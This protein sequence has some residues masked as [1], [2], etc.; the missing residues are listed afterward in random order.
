MTRNHCT[1]F[2]TIP[3]LFLGCSKV[4]DDC[5]VNDYPN[6]PII[7]W[8]TEV[9]GSE[10]ESH[11]HFILTC[12][13]EGYLQVGETGVFPST[14]KILV[15]KTDNLGELVWKKEFGTS[16]NN[17]GNSAIETPTGYIICGAIDGN[18]ALI[19]LDKSTGNQKFVRTIENGGSNAFENII[20][21]PN[22][23]IAVGYNHAEDYTNTFFTEGRGYITFL[24]TS[25]IKTLGIGLENYLAQ[26]YRI[27]DY[28]NDYYISGLT[29]NANDY[30]LIKL[31]SLGNILWHRTYGGVASDHC[32]GMAVG[33]DG[34]IFLTGH[35]LSNTENWDTYTI[36]IDPFGNV[37]WERVAGNPRGFNPKFIH[38]EAWDIKCLPDGSCIVV[39]GTGDEYRRYTRRCGNDGDNSNT[40]HIYLIKYDPDGNLEWQKTYGGGQNIDWAGEA[41]DLTPDGG[42]II[43][44]DNGE[45]GFVKI[46]P[47]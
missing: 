47:L 38:D 6:A 26:A 1:F 37:M 19:K 15:V 20:Q 25:G 39:A 9:S 44:S 11:G 16:G 13:D 5:S 3:Y 31:D 41:I 33:E 8:E 34:S 35:T 28:N 40:W 27:I 21:S 7:E 17:L 43:A 24:D 45:F 10:E 4:N 18:S 42:A 36:K 2:V 46:A 29:E 14:A 32:F 22:G 23:F 12:S 30:G